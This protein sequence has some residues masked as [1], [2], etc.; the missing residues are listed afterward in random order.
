MNPSKVDQAL[1]LAR[2]GSKQEAIPILKEVLVVEPNNEKAWLCLYYCVERTEQK[3]Y[4]LREAL[5]INPANQK[6]RQELD[7][8]VAL[9]SGGPQAGAADSGRES[10]AHCGKPVSAEA[11]FCP[12]CGHP[13]RGG[14]SPAI[15]AP[16]QPTRAEPAM[17]TWGPETQVPSTIVAQPAP[18]LRCPVCR[19]ENPP[20][21]NLCAFCGYNFHPQLGNTATPSYVASSKPEP[22]SGRFRLRFVD[23]GPLVIAVSLFLPWATIYQNTFLG[24]RMNYYDFFGVV[25]Q[26]DGY[27][28]VNIAA[29]IYLLLGL[30]AWVLVR[31]RL[32]PLAVLAALG[33]VAAQIY[34]LVSINDLSGIPSGSDGWFFELATVSLREGVTV[35]LAGV[36]IVLIGTLFYRTDVSP[37]TR[38][39][40]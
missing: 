20:H 11:A 27:G 24:N 9:T 17:S 34:T 18:V 28:G 33:A 40:I 19:S 39:I 4:C 15:G 13:T 32:K 6:V 7:K 2:N 26:F 29:M 23:L 22:E 30:G 14:Y 3:K 35:G 1:T 8:L 38:K 36:V 21:A 31:A 5:R 37:D 10:C 12:S 16:V 25:N